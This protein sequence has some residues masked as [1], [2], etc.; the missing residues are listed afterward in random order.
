MDFKRE[1]P[2]LGEGAY[3]KVRLVKINGSDTDVGAWKEMYYEHTMSGFGNVRELEILMR[4]QKKSKFIPRIILIDI[5]KHVYYPPMIH[6]ESKRTEFLSFICEAAECDGVTFFSGMMKV[7]EGTRRPNYTIEQALKMIAE[8]LMAIDHMHNHNI[9]HRDIKPG[10]VLIFRQPDG[11]PLLKVTDF[12]FAKWNANS[13]KKSPKINTDWYR[14]PEVVWR[15]DNYKMT[16]DMWCVGCTIYEILTG[17]PLMRT[18]GEADEADVIFEKYLQIIPNEWTPAL[19]GT[20]RKHT[21][22]YKSM[23]V[24]GSK[25]IRRLT[26][27]RASFMRQFESSPLYRSDSNPEFWNSMESIL[28]DCLTFDYRERKTARGLLDMVHFERLRPYITAELESQK[29]APEL[30]GIRIDV[31]EAFHEAKCRY[32]RQAYQRLKDTVKIRS[33][34]HA[35]DLANRFI[36]TCPENTLDPYMVCGACLYF[37][38]KYFSI[39]IVPEVPMEF[40]FLSFSEDALRTTAA[41]QAVDRFVYDFEKLIIRD[42]IKRAIYRNG[43]FE[44]QDEYE[45]L[46]LEDLE[47]FLMDFCDMRVWGYGRSF[48]FMYRQLYR[49]HID[50]DFPLD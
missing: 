43:L 16:T 44:A 28:M 20:Y 1:G 7:N 38:N 2:T 26:H 17:T 25:T 41:H 32:F 33:F 12:G 9:Y 37:Y 8:L 30:D 40:F 14:A 22:H 39:M 13:C 36:A 10:N 48:R 23:K 46:N 18:I 29:L 4:L 45:Y 47:K 42:F 3:G 34:F 15:L 31:P 6:N 35:I 19:Q 50:P 11:T 21:S 27:P 49:R 24:F 5:K